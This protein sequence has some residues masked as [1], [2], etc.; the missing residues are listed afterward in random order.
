MNIKLKLNKLEMLKIKYKI[1][2]FFQLILRIISKLILNIIYKS[3]KIVKIFLKKDLKL[4]SNNKNLLFIFMVI[5]LLNLIN[6]N[7]FIKKQC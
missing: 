6:T 4:K 2:N 5:F 3:L 1:L 7:T